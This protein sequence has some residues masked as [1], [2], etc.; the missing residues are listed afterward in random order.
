MTPKWTY[1][2]IDY[3]FSHHIQREWVVQTHQFTLANI[4]LTKSTL[5][6]HK[7]HR[8]KNFFCVCMEGCIP[9][10]ICRNN[11]HWL[12]DEGRKGIIRSNGFRFFCKV[13]MQD[14]LCK[15]YYWSFSV[16]PDHNRLGGGT[17]KDKWK[18]F[19]NIAW[20]SDKAIYVIV[21]YNIW[22]WDLTLGVLLLFVDLTVGW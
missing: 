13:L 22:D 11:T 3:R 10:G 21:M 6:I 20:E 17:E 5:L 7:T 15:M 16:C 9:E 1:H 12:R 14:Q 4:F 19:G 18:V 2:W 8:K